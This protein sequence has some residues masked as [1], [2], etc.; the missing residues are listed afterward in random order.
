M[1]PTFTTTSVSAFRSPQLR[2]AQAQLSEIG[3][4]DRVDAGDPGRALA[5]VDLLA[6]R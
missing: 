6:R 5:D 1:L 3:R 4:E 2:L